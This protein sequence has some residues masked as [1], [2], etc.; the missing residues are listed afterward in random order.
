MMSVLKRPGTAGL[1]CAGAAA[2]IAVVYLVMAGAPVRYLAINLAAFVVGLAAYATV[3]LPRWR[4]GAA[5]DYVLPALGL[6]L[7]TT[8]LF[9]TAVE[10][11]TRWV[12]VG[13]LAL[14]LSLI[15]LPAMVVG[16]ARSPNVA[17]AVGMG[18][19]ALALAVQPDRAMAG[20]PCCVP[21]G[22]GGEPAR[23]AGPGRVRTRRAGA[24]PRR[25]RSLMRCLQCPMST[26]FFYSSFAIH[27]L[28]G[29]A[30]IAG[31]CLLCLPG[32]VAGGGD[33]AIGAVFAALWAGVSGGGCARQ[34]PDAAGRLW[35]QRDRRLSAE[36]R[37]A[38]AGKGRR[39]R[40]VWR[41]LQAAGTRTATELH[42]PWRSAEKASASP[43]PCLTAGLRARDGCLSG[44]AG[45]R[46]EREMNRTC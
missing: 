41:E 16:F 8:S 43:G 10:G 42:W 1:I 6:V 24:L 40:A 38:G 36:R 45:R 34:L 11:A 4:L 33:M 37:A 25:W 17:G 44:A 13:P 12:I 20:G 18:L 22:L 15:L 28:L 21:A 39:A 3:V 7:L 2:A 26:R 19:A 30:L 32:L 23:W 31:A 46:S 9:G 14:Q 5:A 29:S 27:P 35:R